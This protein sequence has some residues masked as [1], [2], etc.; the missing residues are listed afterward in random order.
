ML[1]EDTGFPWLLV[2]SFE[3][4]YI[5]LLY[6]L[7]SPC[8]LSGLNLICLFHPLSSDSLLLPKNKGL[9]FSTTIIISNEANNILKQTSSASEDC[10][11]DGTR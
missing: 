6:I 2:Q 3:I 4:C 10:T 7:L 8:Y 9:Q 11:R 5:T 1:K